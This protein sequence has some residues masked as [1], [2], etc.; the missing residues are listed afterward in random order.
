VKCGAIGTGQ[1]IKDHF[2]G[3]AAHTVGVFG[4]EGG[5]IRFH[6]VGQHV[7]AGG[8]SGSGRQ[9][10]HII[11]VDDCHFGH[12]LIANQRPLHS[13]VGIGND[14][15]GCTFGSGTSGGG[16]ADQ[17]GFLAHLREE[18]DSLTDI[19]EDGGH[20]QEGF[21]GMLVHDPH[22]LRSVD[23]GAT[24]HGNDDIGLELMHLGQTLHSVLDLGIDTDIEELGSLN[25]RVT[26]LVNNGVAG[27]QLIQS[28]VGD[29]ESAF[30]VINF[31]HLPQSHG[32]A[33]GFEIDLLG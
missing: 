10:H 9:L 19:Q 14:G 26:Q 4:S 12:H 27:T 22:D 30:E 6:S 15:E 29:N 8:L 25:A 13:S 21:F 31:L 5:D 11:S 2:R 24:A 7:I 28:G 23:G 32:G 16:D 1:V 33:A 3:V 17:L 18:T 20:V